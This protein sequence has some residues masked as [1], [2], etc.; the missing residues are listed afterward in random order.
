MK[1]K[2]Y[3]LLILFVFL[4]IIQYNAHAQTPLKTLVII[5]HPDD[6]SMLSVTLYKLAKE[7]HGQVDLFVITNGEA[8]YRYSTL[9]EQYYGLKL[10]DAAD[11]RKNLPAIRKKELHEAGEVLGIS[12]YYFG[13]QADSHYSTDEHEPLDTSWHVPAVKQQLHQL[14]IQNHYNYVFCL[15]PEADTHAGHKAATLLALDVVASL[16]ANE[17]PIVLGAALRNKADD[18]K[19]F[20]QLAAYERTTAI[21]TAPSFSV[22]RTTSFSYRNKINYKIIANWELAA[23]KSQGA[24]QMTMNDGDL[25]EFW[26][27][28]INSPEKLAQTAQLFERLSQSPYVQQQWLSQTSTKP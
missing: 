23:H 9:A 18:V 27:F 20:K 28:K 4:G 15:L 26:Y 3:Q 2:K 5:A 17:R 24:T 10:T 16:P 21:S 22:D 11:A 8:G 7:Q 19:T 6:E 14:L 1:P 13:N 12:H 25:E